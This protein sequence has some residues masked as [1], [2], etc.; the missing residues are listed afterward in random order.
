MEFVDF[1]VQ[2]ISTKTLG[3]KVATAAMEAAP[4]APGQKRASA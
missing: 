2:P 3:T 1:L 4:L